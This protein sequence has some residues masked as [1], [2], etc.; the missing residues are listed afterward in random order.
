M[1]ESMGGKNNRKR[2]LS[3]EDLAKR[4]K[5]IIEDIKAGTLSYREIALKNGVSL[6]TVNNK[7]RKAGISRGRRRGARIVVAA[8]LRRAG[9]KAVARA[10]VRRRVRAAV[11]SKVAT[12]VAR[13][14][15][16]GRPPGRRGRPR[17]AARTQADFAG[18]FRELVLKHY[19]N[20]S[21]IVFDRLARL[22]ENEV[23]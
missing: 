21:L 12:A 10:V 11:V 17:G 5:Q 18:A 3:K 22:V 15:G 8:K 20:I 19:P 14:R 16:P 13:R 1:R 7:A 23:S 9:K 6:P 2:R 4:E